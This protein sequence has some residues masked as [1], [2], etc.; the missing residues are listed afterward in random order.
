M[1]KV[2]VYGSEANESQSTDGTP[3]IIASTSAP[4]SSQGIDGDIWLQ[5]N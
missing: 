3:N 2:R 5:Y 4:T 1:S